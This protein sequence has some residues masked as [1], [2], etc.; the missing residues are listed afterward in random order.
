MGTNST[1]Q[2]RNLFNQLMLIMCTQGKSG[3]EVVQRVADKENISVLYFNETNS[4]LEY[5]N[6]VNR[7]IILIISGSYCKPIINTLEKNKNI[8]SIVIYCLNV[9]AILDVARKHKKIVSIT[10]TPNVLEIALCKAINNFNT[11]QEMSNIS[12]QGVDY[13]ALL[14]YLNLYNG[15][16]QY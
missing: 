14:N 12:L 8:S 5:L 9:K 10:T 15:L 13:L 7:K 3:L 11:A 1:N 2:K 16:L 4:L 6:Q